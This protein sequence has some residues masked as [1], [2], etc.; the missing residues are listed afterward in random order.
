MLQR[1]RTE[2]LQGPRNRGMGQGGNRV[3]PCNRFGQIKKT[4]PVP[5]IYRLFPLP[6][7][8]RLPSYGPARPFSCEIYA[9]N[10]Y[11]RKVGCSLH[12]VATDVNANLNAATWK[13]NNLR[14]LANSISAMNF[15]QTY[16]RCWFAFTHVGFLWQFMFW[17]NEN[18]EIGLYE[19]LRI[20]GSV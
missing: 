1:R 12:A 11:W 4:K 8:L 15:S 19:G 3:P 17:K 13:E 16:W 14:K 20:R 18:H 2:L 7:S 6:P 5:L 10:I 9:Y